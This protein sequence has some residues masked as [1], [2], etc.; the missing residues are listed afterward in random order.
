MCADSD[1]VMTPAMR[2]AGELGSPPD[3]SSDPAATSSAIARKPSSS[4][5]LAPATASSSVYSSEAGNGDPGSSSGAMA[6][7]AEITSFAV[8]FMARTRTS[9][10]AMMVPPAV[11]EVSDFCRDKAPTTPAAPAPYTVT[12]AAVS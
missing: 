8:A 2:K 9:P 3:A 11:T 4:V 7:V 5:C 10:P 12:S 6:E 1:Q